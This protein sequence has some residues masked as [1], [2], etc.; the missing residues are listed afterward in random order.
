MPANTVHIRHRPAAPRT[1][2]RP[3]ATMAPPAAASP[4]SPGRT[5]VIPSRGIRMELRKLNHNV[6]TREGQRKIQLRRGL[7]SGDLRHQSCKLT[8][9]WSDHAWFLPTPNFA[10]AI[11]GLSPDLQHPEESRA[12]KSSSS[13]GPNSRARSQPPSTSRHYP[14]GE[15]RSVQSPAWRGSAGE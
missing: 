9:V 15:G 3:A 11:L 10:S 6:G 1:V 7:I 5:R 2:Q 12:C 8:R 13:L 14:G 4:G